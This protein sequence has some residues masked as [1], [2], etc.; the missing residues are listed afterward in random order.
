M[1]SLLS[2]VIQMLLIVFMFEIRVSC[3]NCYSDVRIKLLHHIYKLSDLLL[4]TLK[5]RAFSCKS[6]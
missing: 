2:E 3:R 4:L 1:P 6:F 5:S